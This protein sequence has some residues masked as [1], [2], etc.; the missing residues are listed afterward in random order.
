MKVLTIAGT[1]LRRLFRWRMNIFFLFALPMM[2]ILLL[3][4]AFGGSNKARIGVLGGAEGKLAR[5]FVATL[6]HQP[7]TKLIGYSSRSSLQ[8][9]VARGNIDAG[10]IVPA[11]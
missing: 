2:I 6:R 4:A 10:L 11:N 3:G 7:S 8:D 9:A 1:D 5:Q